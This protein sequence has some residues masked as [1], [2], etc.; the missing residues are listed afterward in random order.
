MISNEALRERRDALRRLPPVFGYKDGQVKIDTTAAERIY[1]FSEGEGTSRMMVMARSD[2]T[3]CAESLPDLVLT[4]PEM[5]LEGAKP[6]TEVDGGD[7]AV[8]EEARMILK[9]V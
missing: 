8:K 7:A 5:D 4:P 6:E 9:K 2:I 1:Q 3:A